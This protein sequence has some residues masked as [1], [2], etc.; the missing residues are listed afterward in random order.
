MIQWEKVWTIATK[1]FKEFR[2]NKYILYSIILMPLL[3]ATVLP[4]IYVIPVSMFAA[5]ESKTPMDLHLNIN[6]NNS[7]IEV[8]EVYA[9]NIEF[10]SCNLTNTV[11]TGCI[12]YNCTLTNCVVEGSQLND[13]IVL[14][15]TITKC[16]LNNVTRINSTVLG[17]VLVG[18][19]TTA[20]TTLLLLINTMLL[21]FLIMPTIVPAVVASYTIVG[22]KLNR[23]LEPLLMTPT[24]DLEL[25][26]GKSTSIFVPTVLMT[27]L[28]FVPFVLI[29]DFFTYP[30]LGYAP[31][32]SDVFVIAVYLISPLTC[33]L[34]ILAN[35]IISSRVN[36]V[37]SAQQLGS[38]VVL[39]MVILF[40][41]ALAGV[42]S[43]NAWLMLGFGGLI[44]AADVVMLLISLRL[45][46][47]EEILVNWK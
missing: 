28:A 17:S 43:L 3:L 20:E 12:F 37:R 23:S 6:L 38:L 45:F 24:T 31:L 15:S 29:V 18:E 5:D 22:E 35:I 11:A 16:N 7:Y 14:G 9:A 44:L 30:V 33:A 46:K 41:A 32:P 13:S 25:M 40:I 34:S 27:Y 4:A 21:F 2:R 10:T 19:M 47:R 1:E 8:R 26:L 36:D 42:A 39:P